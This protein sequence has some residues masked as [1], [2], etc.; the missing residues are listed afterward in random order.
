MR[1]YLTNIG[2][3]ILRYSVLTG[4]GI[5]FYL[6][7]QEPTL[8]NIILFGVFGVCMLVICALDIKKAI[9]RFINTPE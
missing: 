8:V 7:Y 2:S 4:I 6:D 5:W 9:Q 3:I 1:K